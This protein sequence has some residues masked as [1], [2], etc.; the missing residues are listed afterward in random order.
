M[1]TKPFLVDIDARGLVLIGSIPNNVGNFLTVSTVDGKTISRR[2]NAQVVTDLG[3]MS[4]T[5]VANTITGTNISN[6]DTAFGWGNHAGLYS[7]SGHTHNYLPLSGGTLTGSLS[8]NSD[9]VYFTVDTGNARLGFT[10]KAG[11]FPILTYAN[12]TP[13]VIAESSGGGIQASFTF[14]PRLTISNGGN[15]TFSGTVSTP[16]VLVG[17]GSPVAGGVTLQGG[18]IGSGHAALRL[19][20]FNPFLG[21]VNTEN[22][23]LG[24]G[25]NNTVSLYVNPS[26]NLGI[27]GNTDASRLYITG[28]INASG[29]LARGTYHSETLTATANNDVLVGVDINPSYVNGAFTDVSN[30]GLRVNGVTSL[31]F[32]RVSQV[33]FSTVP[34]GNMSTGI[35]GVSNNLSFLTGGTTQG[36]FFSNTGNLLLQNGGT[37]TDNGYRLDTIGKSRVHNLDTTTG[38]NW[39]L[40]VTNNTATV[41]STT[42]ILIGVGDINSV[43]GGIIFKRTGS[44]GIGDLY[45]LTSSN[46]NSTPITVATD[47]K[48]VIKSNG[49]TLIGSIIDNGFKFEVTGTTKLLGD[50]VIG[51]T[52]TSGYK[53]DVTG[54]TR[55]LLTNTNVIENWPLTVQNTASNNGNTTGILFITG[56]NNHFKAGI[57]FKRTSA[58]GVGTGDLHFLNRTTTDLTSPTIADDTKLLLTS[59]GNFIIGSTTNSGFKLDVNGTSRLYG[60]TTIRGTSSSD[61]PSAGTNI[62][63]TGTVDASWTGSDF[64]T[65]YTHVPGSVTTIVANSALSNNVYNITWTITN[66]TAGSFILDF[67]GHTQVGINNTGSIQPRTSTTGALTITPTSDFNGTIVLSIQLVTISTPLIE[68]YNSSNTKLFQQRGSGATNVFIGDN[69]GMYNSSGIGNTFIGN[70]AGVFNTTATNNSFL[71]YQA[72]YLNSMGVNNSYVGSQTGFNTTTGN[73]NSFLGYQAGFTASTGSQNTFLG[74]RS[75]YLTTTGS[76]NTF[77]GYESGYGNTTGSGNVFLG[78]DAGRYIANG[79][80]VNTTSTSS[81]LIGLNSKVLADGQTNQL[82]VGHAV[83]GLG[84]NT[85]VFGNTATVFGRWYGN[86]LLG[87]NTNSSYMLDVAGTTRLL[88][89]TRIEGTNNSIFTSSI[90]NIGKVAG[91]FGSD[92]INYASTT[93]EDLSF[94]YTRTGTARW[95]HLFSGQTMEWLNNV[96]M[97]VFH[98]DNSGNVGI[99][100]AST[101]NR[102]EVTGTLRTTGVNTLSNLTGT[103]NRFVVVS[104]TGVLSAPANPTTLAGYGITNSIIEGGGT[105]NFIPIF[106]GATSV[107]NSKAFQDSNGLNYKETSTSGYSSFT[108]VNDNGLSTLQV[109]VYN[110]AH[111][112]ANKAFIFAGGNTT[113]LGITVGGNKNLTV[114]ANDVSIAKSLIL[115]SADGNSNLDIGV[116]V[117]YKGRLNYNYSTKVLSLGAG[118]LGDLSLTVGDIASPIEAI[119]IKNNGFVGI[120]TN[121]PLGYLWAPTTGD[122]AQSKLGMLTINSSGV[123]G[124]VGTALWTNYNPVTNT[125][126]LTDVSWGLQMGRNGDSFSISRMPSNSTVAVSLLSITNVGVLSSYGNIIAPTFIGAL[127]GNATTATNVTWSGITSK[128]T[129]IGGFGIT[130]FNSLGDARW[131]LTSHTQAWSTITDSTSIDAINIART[132]VTGGGTITISAT[133]DVLWSQRFILMSNGNGSHF[134]TNGYFDITCPTSGTITGVGGATNKTA[135]AAGIPLTTWDVLYYILPIGGN[136]SSIAANFRV[137]NYTSAFVI[138]YTWIKICARAEGGYVEFATGTSLRPSTSLNTNSFD[139]LGADVSG[140]VASATILATSRNINGVAFNGSAN[141]TVADATKLPLSGGALTGSLTIPNQVPLILG[142][143]GGTNGYFRLI[144]SGGLN[145]IQSG[146]GAVSGTRA[147]LIIGGNNAGSETVRFKADGTTVFTASVTAPT[148]IGNLAGNASSATTATNILN[149]GTVT[150]ASATESNAITITQPSYSSNQ[151]VKLLNFN[152]YSDTWSFGNIR[153]AGTASNGLGVFINGAEQVRFS[154]AGTVT[155]T[156]F[157]GTIFN[158]AGTGL[159]GTA[160]SLI[161][162]KSIVLDRVGSTTNANTMFSDTPA[163]TMGWQDAYNPTNGGSFLWGNYL[164][165]RHENG[166]A[167]YGTQLYINWEGTDVMKYR[168]VY[169]NTFS[170]WKTLLDSSNFGTYALPKSGGDM[171]GNIGR[172]AHSSGHLVGSFNSVGGNGDKS[173]PIYT[174][175]SSYLPTDSTL[176][177][178]YGIGFSN[179]SFWG[180]GKGSGWGLYVAEAGIVRSTISVSGIWSSGSITGTGLIS[181]SYVSL[182]GYL[183]SIDNGIAGGNTAFEIIGITDG[184]T[185]TYGSRLSLKTF[186]YNGSAYVFREALSL[187]ANLTA[188]FASSVTATGTIYASGSGGFACTTYVANGR[189]PIY[190]LGNATPYGLSYFQGTAGVVSG[191]DAIGFHFGTATA[192][193]SKF[194]MSQDGTFRS[195]GDVIAFYSSDKRLKDNIKPIPNALDKISKIGGYTFEWNDKQNVYSGSDIG[196]IAQ[197]IEEILPELVDT[198]DNGYKAVKYEKLVALLIEGIKEQATV[199]KNLEL[200]I[201][202]LE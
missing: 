107:A 168:S 155:A 149:T 130:D 127:S 32:L 56:N 60:M 142:D 21:L 93:G 76:N 181:N 160:A 171:S 14:T 4:T 123:T 118:Y 159:T 84:S 180:A 176:G 97:S 80:T 197:E 48:L 169:N 15:A 66:R 35:H 8:I 131:S 112:S 157:N 23:W 126:D 140:A 100:G 1:P 28:N 29:L 68:L 156:T 199:I 92:M 106:S 22:S 26:G 193:G 120:G 115:G 105:N 150:L 2:T 50:T 113:E 27:G 119:R 78:H 141:I 179:E 125:K 146:I 7:L 6:W 132:V 154:T 61:A 20:G 162:G 101:G 44:F 139:I 94:S 185:G 121:N 134:S 62:L 52:S 30:F 90:L 166:G 175:G 55:A 13:F 24:L 63:T 89:N 86:L 75:G 49:N 102:L 65:G 104:S 95:R 87:T 53:L 137:V 184:S 71:G 99:G 59:S 116:D 136:S 167:S 10:K 144:T 16:Q 72:G 133:Y 64:T 79:S 39:N 17:S 186:G 148:F 45:F 198:R 25:A 96:S 174:I 40:T 82:V 138:P 31:G 201:S 183:R 173:N 36:Q 83:T 124:Y 85:S 189:S 12:T 191:V 194:T 37:Y 38:E 103:G 47:A 98:A 190:Y 46:A 163:G 187:G 70:R 151:P 58:G 34:N 196:V 74:T 192:A 73:N 117:Y 129:T 42:G 177:N 51:G 178:M 41:G 147:D 188:S 195:T 69:N 128:P 67:G 152:W 3:V 114:S 145:Y 18:N 153:S 122:N 5:H 109:G 172:S 11:G 9:D 110:S 182:N 200:R 19:T 202:K 161:A 54:S 81:I 77:L 108:A 57:I 88:G 170:S 143:T 135:T 164:N 158:G 43:K 111:A 91:S 165:M 33:A